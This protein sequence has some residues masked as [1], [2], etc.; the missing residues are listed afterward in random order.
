MRFHRRVWA[1][2]S[3]IWRM[4]H[5]G[6]EWSHIKSYDDTRHTDVTNGEVPGLGLT[7]EDISLLW[8]RIVI[9]WPWVDCVIY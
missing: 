2:V 1:R 5:M 7:D 6:L 9:S 8:R 3:G 4:A